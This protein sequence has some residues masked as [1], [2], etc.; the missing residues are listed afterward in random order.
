[1]LQLE[2]PPGKNVSEKL[3]DEMSVDGFMSAGEPLLVNQPAELLDNSVTML[4]DFSLGY[5]KGQARMNTLFDDLYDLYKAGVKKEDLEA[6]HYTFWNACRAIYA[7][8]LDKGS[9]LE[10]ALVNMKV[11][12]QGSIRRANNVIQT[13]VI[14]RELSKHGMPDFGFQGVNRY[15]VPPPEY[16][17]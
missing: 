5:I 17:F 6:T 8:P 1:M 9:K 4:P 2:A 12:C 14:I 13:V 10:D 15:Y 7:L 3:I 16:S 11:S